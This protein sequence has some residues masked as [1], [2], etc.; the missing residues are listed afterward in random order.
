MKKQNATK[1][2][3]FAELMEGVEA[4]KAQREGKVTL[5]SHAVPVP[6]VEQSPGAEFFVAAR[7]QFNVSRAVWANMLRVS[8]RTVEK[9]EQ[10]GQ[11][12]PLAA[13]FVELVTRFPDTIERLQTLPRRVARTSRG[14]R[15]TGAVRSSATRARS[16]RRAGNGSSSLKRSATVG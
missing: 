8:P 11:V 15:R 10:G 6:N 9:W 2:N 1:R 16:S 13:T 14:R 5:R 3:L 4:M 7:E 12:S